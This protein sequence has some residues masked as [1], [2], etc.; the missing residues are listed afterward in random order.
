MTGRPDPAGR[1]GDI[2]KHL[3]KW[4]PVLLMAVLIAGCANQ[5]APAEAALKVA[6]D[7]FAAIKT[8]AATYV[9]DQAKGAED[10]IADARDQFA[11]NDYAAAL[12]SAQAIPAK[13]ED[14]KAAV[15]AKKNE[16]T[17]TWTS[18]SEGLPGMVK[19]I[20]TR[21]DILSK[22]KKLPKGL[23]QAAFDGAKANLAAVT[24]TWTDAT[25]AFSGGDLMAAVTKAQEVKTKAT[26]IMTTLGMQAPP[27]AAAK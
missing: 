6:D 20:Q 7:A 14:L 2:V 4:I 8:E 3:L 12:T 22:S 10:A 21:V 19:A 17:A 9:P 18:M 23:D 26:E 1:E 25:S 27:A 5:K 11:K 15:T 16:L 24:Q 13:I